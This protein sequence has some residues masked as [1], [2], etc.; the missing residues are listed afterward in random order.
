MCKSN[1]FDDPSHFVV[2]LVVYAHQDRQHHSFYAPPFPKVHVEYKQWPVSTEKTEV[3]LGIVIQI[4]ENWWT[5]WNMRICRLDIQFHSSRMFSLIY[6]P[7][8]ECR[9]FR[10]CQSSFYMKIHITGHMLYS[11]K[12]FISILTIS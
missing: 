4:C 11:S 9:I 1:T 2:F 5:K 6:V 12:I 3:I 10:F 8:V 7:F